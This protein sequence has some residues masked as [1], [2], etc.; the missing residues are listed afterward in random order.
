MPL[1]DTEGRVE[2]YI[3]I[4]V[5]ISKRKQKELQLIEQLKEKSCLYAIHR[6]MVLETSLQKLCSQIIK[7]LTL[8]M[9]FPEIAVCSIKLFQ[10]FFTSD[11]YQS[12]LSNYISTKIKVSGNVCG[13][14]SVFYTEDKPF[15]LPDEQN[16]INFI[17]EDPAPPANSNNICCKIKFMNFLRNLCF[18]A[19]RNHLTQ[20]SF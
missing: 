13:R 6:D 7:H 19:K 10:E 8:A 1:K 5:D 16:L 2:R 9:R 4:R 17:A 12:D 3:S 15:I 11:N 14:L 20:V 18:E